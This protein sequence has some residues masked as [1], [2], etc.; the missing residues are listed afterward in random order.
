MNY[1]N[2]PRVHDRLVLTL[3][4]WRLQ[5]RWA[6]RL[7]RALFGRQISVYAAWDQWFQGHLD[8]IEANVRTF[9]T[10]YLDVMDNVWQA[11]PLTNTNR[12]RQCECDSHLTLEYWQLSQI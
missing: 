8:Y 7:D 4:E 3:T 1:Y 6:E 12:T 2:L 5:L 11:Q 9:V 10:R